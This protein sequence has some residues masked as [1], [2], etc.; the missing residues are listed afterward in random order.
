ML[1]SFV[2]ILTCAII[3]TWLLI[4][5]DSNSELARNFIVTDFIKILYISLLICCYI[6]LGVLIAI[7]INKYCIH[8]SLSIHIKNR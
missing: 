8:E 1:M 2:V 5:A 4:S 7:F 3:L 6:L